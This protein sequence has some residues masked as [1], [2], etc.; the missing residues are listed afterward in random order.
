[1]SPELFFRLASLLLNLASNYRFV[2]TGSAHNLQ[3]WAAHKAPAAVGLDTVQFKQKK[4]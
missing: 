4:L 3:D 2:P 1:M